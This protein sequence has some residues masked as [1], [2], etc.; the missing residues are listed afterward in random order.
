MRQFSTW[1]PS[2]GKL[3]PKFGN[4]FNFYTSYTTGAAKVNATKTMHAQTVKYISAEIQKCSLGET[5]FMG[6]NQ[7]C[8][9]TAAKAVTGAVA[10]MTDKNPY[11]MTN[12][13]IR[14]STAYN[15]GYVSV[16]ASSSTSVLINT[17]TKTGCATADKMTATISVD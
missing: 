11:S 5:K 15:E 2:L 14:S 6:T 16:S 9:A 7:D 10:T 12:N 4:F 13:A 17:C 8:P 1:V 3:L